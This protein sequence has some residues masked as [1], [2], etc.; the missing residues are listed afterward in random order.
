MKFLKKIILL[1][2]TVF[3]VNACSSSVFQQ[4]SKN[5]LDQKSFAVG[6]G[7]AAQTYEGRVN[8]SYDIES[9]IKGV[10]NFYTGQVKLPIEQ[11]RA[12]TLNRMMDHDVYAYNMG[13]LFASDLKAN[14]YKISA[15]CWNLVDSKSITQGIYE[16]MI[17]LQKD[18]VRH[19]DYIKNGYD[20]LLH[21][22]VKKVEEAETK[23][24]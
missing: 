13:I 10:D 2:V 21:T 4:V 5:N 22:C 12:N 1:V 23:Q 8:Q 14:F 17:D 16:A 15:D 7:T 19:D 11:I 9:F 6:Y 3:V 24:K 20:E 18:Q